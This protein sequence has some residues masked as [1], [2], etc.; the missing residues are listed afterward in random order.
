LLSVFISMA[1]IVS[2]N[3]FRGVGIAEAEGSNPSLTKNQVVLAVC[4]LN[5]NT[6]VGNEARIHNHIEAFDRFYR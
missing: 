2:R 3:N 1:L 4:R 5:L 6:F